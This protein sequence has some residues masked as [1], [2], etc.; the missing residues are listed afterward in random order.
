MTKKGINKS[1]VI[2]ISKIMSFVYLCLSFSNPKNI[3]KSTNNK[4]INKIT[5]ENGKIKG[6]K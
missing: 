1:R 2:E 6:K 5:V 3:L 4:Q